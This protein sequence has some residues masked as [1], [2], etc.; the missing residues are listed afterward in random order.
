MAS[1]MGHLEVVKIL[2]ADPRVDPSENDNYGFYELL[3]SFLPRA[4]FLAT[5]P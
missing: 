5:I 4:S 3:V 1:K 2:L